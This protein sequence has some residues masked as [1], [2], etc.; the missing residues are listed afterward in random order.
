MSVDRL[1]CF[2]QELLTM[3]EPGNALS[4]ASARAILDNL[5]GLL[6][7]SGKC[8]SIVLRIADRFRENFVYYCH[9]REEFAGVPGEYQ[10]NQAKRDRLRQ[11]LYPGC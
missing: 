7:S 6:R 4:V 3:L 5:C 1:I 9:H 2:L 11:T 10:Q 8:S